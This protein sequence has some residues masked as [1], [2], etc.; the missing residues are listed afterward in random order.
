MIDD[1]VNHLVRPL[2]IY[3]SVRHLKPVD[4]ST[5]NWCPHVVEQARIRAGCSTQA[6]ENR[7]GLS[8]VP[9]PQI[10]QLDHFY[11]TKRP[12]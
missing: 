8:Q 1:L 4:R 9:D 11:F 10:L 6:S 7:E 2:R 12:F 3:R 5:P